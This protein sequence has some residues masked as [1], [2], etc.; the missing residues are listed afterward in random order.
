MQKGENPS[1]L[2]KMIGK[3]SAIAISGGDSHARMSFV[4]PED[5]KKGDTIHMI[6][7][8]TDDGEHNLSYYQRV[9]ITVSENGSDQPANIAS[10]ED[11][12]Q[13]ASG[14]PAQIKN[15]ASPAEEDAKGEEQTLV[16]PED[17]KQPI[18]AE[19]AKQAD[20]TEPQD[21]EAAQT[22]SNVIPED[23]QTPE[24]EAAP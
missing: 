10:S 6:A 20:Q 24:G 8:A 17:S 5:A 22:D 4:V 21:K 15:A 16:E 9:I 18:E 19:D 7:K 14:G 11:S 13:L 23:L 3:P 12:E 1:S 2:V